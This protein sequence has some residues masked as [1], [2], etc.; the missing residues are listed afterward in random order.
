MKQNKIFYGWL[1]CLTGTLMLVGG[2][3]IVVNCAGQFLVPVT[4]TLGVS[5]SE[6]SLYT[7]MVS[8]ASMIFCPL[9]GKVYEKIPPRLATV[10]GGVFMAACWTGLSFA[11]SIGQFYVIGFLIGTGSSLCGM[12]SVNILMNN[13]FYAK[14]G[15]AMAPPVTGLDRKS[16][17]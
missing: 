12:V 8:V 10:A 6:F 2:S 5:R 4:E 14:K 9:I 11:R 15:T 3:G 1:L 13:W 17:V 7:S 16:V